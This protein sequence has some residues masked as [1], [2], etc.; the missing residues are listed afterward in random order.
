MSTAWFRKKDQ[1]EKATSNWSIQHATIRRVTPSRS[2]YFQLVDLL[3][4]KLKTLIERLQIAT[5]SMVAIYMRAA[6]PDSPNS[7]QPS[8]HTSGT[9]QEI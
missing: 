9:V 2:N 3:A 8:T 5:Q 6:N 1:R 4:M 7:T